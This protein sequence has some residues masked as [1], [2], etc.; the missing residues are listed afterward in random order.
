MKSGI[1]QGSILGPILLLFYASDMSSLV[2][3]TAEMFAY[4]IKLYPKIES[5]DDCY[6]LKTDLNLSFNETKC[7]VLKI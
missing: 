3:N 4:D 5:R 1:P 7:V 6:R 2:Q